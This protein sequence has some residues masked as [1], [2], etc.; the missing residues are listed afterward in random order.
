MNEKEVLEK[1]EEIGK[2]LPHF[3]DGRINYTGADYAPVVVVFV[4]YDGKILFLKRSDKVQTYKGKWNTV[5]GYM[6]EIRPIREKVLG[7]LREELNLNE[8]DISKLCIGEAYEE[9]D[10]EID[11]VW[12]ITPAIVKLKKAPKIK[13]DWEHTE[14]RWIKPEEIKD[15]DSVHGTDKSLG[16][17]LAACSK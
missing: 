2:K 11:K 4:E 1:V 16:Y 9:A 5:A 17:A 15:Y 10:D 14:Y 13:I 3:N 7:E 8:A 6:D 12:L